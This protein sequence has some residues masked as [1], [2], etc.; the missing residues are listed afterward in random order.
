MD[1]ILY[2]IFE[3]CRMLFQFKPNKEVNI[4]NNKEQYIIKQIHDTLK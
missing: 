2:V 1:D 3:Q 4:I